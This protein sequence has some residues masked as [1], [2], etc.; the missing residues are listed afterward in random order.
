MSKRLTVTLRGLIAHVCSN[1]ST[2]IT[3]IDT[4]YIIK[5]TCTNQ[6]KVGVLRRDGLVAGKAVYYRYVRVTNER[7]DTKNVI[8]THTRSDVDIV[9]A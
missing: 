3:L 4:L 7:T 2:L 6:G 8:E 1:I 9:P 5:H